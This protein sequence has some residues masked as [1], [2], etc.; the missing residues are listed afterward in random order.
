MGVL[1]AFQKFRSSVAA[2]FGSQTATWWE[3]FNFWWLYFAEISQFFAIYKINYFNLNT[4]IVTN[5]ENYP[6]ACDLY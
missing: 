3:E 6:N 5:N 4:Q 1:A 2:K